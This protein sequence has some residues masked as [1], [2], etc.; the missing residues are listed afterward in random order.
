[1]RVPISHDLPKEEVRHRLSSRSHEIADVVPGGMAEV[2]V[3]WPN[4]D[5]MAVNVVTMGQSLNSRVL[6]EDK[7]VVFEVDLP[8][9]LS[10]VKPMIESAIRSKGEKLL[11]APKT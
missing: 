11:S 3:S 5:T 4:E 10:F 7:Q 2:D 9:A 1:M 6:I 8:M